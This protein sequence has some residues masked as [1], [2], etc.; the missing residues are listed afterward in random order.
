M[1]LAPSPWAFLWFQFTEC[2]VPRQNFSRLGE[3]LGVCTQPESRPWT[4]SSNLR[5]VQATDEVL[6]HHLEANIWANRREET[7]IRG[8][9]CKT[10]LAPCAHLGVKIEIVTKAQRK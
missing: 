3:V 7:R 8:F 9:I 1:A 10:V 2:F 4:I 5:D 6:W